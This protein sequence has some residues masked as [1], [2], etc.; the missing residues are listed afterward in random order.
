MRTPASQPDTDVRNAR[1]H[2]EHEV[3]AL[4]AEGGRDWP[5]GVYY[6]W[7]RREGKWRV[8]NRK[9]ISL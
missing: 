6:E 7:L 5:E 8:E 4:N 3:R 9:W 1:N 2:F